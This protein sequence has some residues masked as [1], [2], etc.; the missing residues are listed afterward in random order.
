MSEF[1]LDW[2]GDLCPFHPVV[3]LCNLARISSCTTTNNNDKWLEAWSFFSIVYIC[4]DS[5]AEIQRL[6]ALVECCCNVFQCGF[7]FLV[8][9]RC[10]NDIFVIEPN[11][12]GCPRNL[13]EK[14]PNKI[15]LNTRFHMHNGGEIFKLANWNCY[16]Q[17][18]IASVYLIKYFYHNW[19]ISFWGNMSQ[20]RSLLLLGLMRFFVCV[21]CSGHAHLLVSV[22]VYFHLF[23]CTQLFVNAF[24]FKP[25]CIFP[26]DCIC[27]CV[28]IAAAFIVHLVRFET[29]EEKK[30]E[31]Q[32]RDSANCA[33][34]YTR[35][36]NKF[37]LV[38]ICYF[39]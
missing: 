1:Y 16:K 15:D 35:A 3:Q 30:N 36:T 8:L 11:L 7:F 18:N 37:G 38:H 27:L 5:H 28:F 32:Q 21:K 10:N 22:F 4:D 29:T 6:S 13:I 19:T 9:F 39:R 23:I 34:S 2:S 24:C 26:L 33:Q 20:H 31:Q 25:I 12:W 14:A 17:W